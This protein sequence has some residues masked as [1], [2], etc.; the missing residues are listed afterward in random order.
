MAQA[1]KLL[2][3]KRVRFRWGSRVGVTVPKLERLL[4]DVQ[5]GSHRWTD[6]H[7]PTP[8]AAGEQIPSGTRCMYIGLLNQRRR[9]ADGSGGGFYFT[10]GS[11]I[12]GKGEHQIPLDFQEGTDEPRID[13]GPIIGRDGRQRSI[14]HEFRCV[15]LGE[16]LIIQNERGGGGPPALA[17]LLAA[18]FRKFSD[19]TLPTIEL[20]DVFSRDL[21][22]VLEAE[23]GAEIMRIRMVGGTANPDDAGRYSTPLFQSRDLVNGVGVFK[24]EWFAAGEEGLDIDQVV[25]AYE[26]AIEADFS[27]INIKTR[28]GGWI[29]DLG[30]YRARDEVFITVD[31]HGIE[32]VN[33]IKPALYDY[34]DKIR[35]FGDDEWRLVDDD[36]MFTVSAMTS[37]KMVKKR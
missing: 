37:V 24:A 11:Y 21:K 18:M 9:Q 25:D 14:L 17:N 26:E 2:Q 29:N 6:R 16:T 13:S 33:E 3:L 28:D 31:R 10:V 7:H 35:V 23:G 15:A 20:V 5:R 4:L 22:K 32:H 12:Y 30:K 8:P 34:L 19:E 36:G 27:K 1:R